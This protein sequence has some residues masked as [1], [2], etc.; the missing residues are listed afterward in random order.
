MANGIPS[1]EKLLLLL[2][3]V[4]EKHVRRGVRFSWLRSLW[5][6]DA[7]EGVAR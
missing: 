5:T 4:G 3:R 7:V 2:L 6:A 1:Q